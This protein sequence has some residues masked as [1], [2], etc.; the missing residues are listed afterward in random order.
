M[1]NTYD[2]EFDGIEPLSNVLLLA[3]LRAATRMAAGMDDAEAEA[4]YAAAFATASARVD[5]LLYNGEYYIQHVNDVNA[6]PHQYGVGV[7]SDQ[8]LGQ[9]QA[10]VNGLGVLL[11]EDHLR[12][13]ISAVFRYNFR[14]DLSQHESV[15]RS[16]A[17]D[18]EGG[19]LLASWPRGGR[20]DAPFSYADEVWTGIEYQ[21]AAQLIYSGYLEEALTVVRAA[22]AR[23]TGQYRSPWDDIEAGH[24]YARSMSAWAL[25][26]ALSG[27]Q[28]DAPARTLSFD[29]VADGTYFFTTNTGWGRATITGT[30][31]QLALDYGTLDLD[32]L[33]LRGH[34]HGPRSLRSGTHRDSGRRH[35][36]G[37]TPSVADVAW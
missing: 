21:V 18:D 17:L 30:Q 25:L 1:H 9:L 10:H 16:Y 15:E 7:L 32:H 22:R 14:P 31:I 26:L 13:A 2:I 4:R 3:A 8:L 11:P 28:Y 6:L 27:V 24:H 5:E 19:L 34:D 37:S 35:P 29:P 20:P 36:E 33:V 23:H 12:S